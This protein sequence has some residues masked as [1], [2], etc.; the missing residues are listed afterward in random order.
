MTCGW[1]V[2]ALEC[3][4]GRIFRGRVSVHVVA[5]PDNLSK[6]VAAVTRARIVSEFSVVILFSPPSRVSRPHQGRL[7]FKPWLAEQFQ[8]QLDAHP[9][10]TAACGALLLVP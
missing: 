6:L 4:S 1:N 2:G 3:C 5:V 9:S 10:K 7:T 8:C